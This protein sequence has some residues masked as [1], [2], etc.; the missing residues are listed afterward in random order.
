MVFV[1]VVFVVGGKLPPTPVIGPSVRLPSSINA[2]VN[3]IL[4]SDLITFVKL[5]PPNAVAVEVL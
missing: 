5:G 4:K 3:V 2:C 1:S